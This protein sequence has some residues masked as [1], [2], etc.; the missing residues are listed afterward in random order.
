MG[1]LS[2]RPKEEPEKQPSHR[3]KDE[4]LPDELYDEFVQVVGWRTETLVK[5]GYPVRY[6]ERLA[7]YVEVDLREAERLLDMG[8]LPKTA[9]EILL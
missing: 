8:C 7:L 6:A 3:E 2:N 4:D 9:V 5:A 1:I